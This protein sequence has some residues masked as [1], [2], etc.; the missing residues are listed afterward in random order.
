METRNLRVDLAR[1]GDV[2][3]K[4]DRKRPLSYEEWEEYSKN[5][6]SGRAEIQKVVNSSVREDGKEDFV[7]NPPSGPFAKD[8]E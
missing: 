1:E 7:N 2:W 8:A 4:A 6:Q 3:K 5:L